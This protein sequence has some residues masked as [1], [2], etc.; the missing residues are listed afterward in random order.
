MTNNGNGTVAGGSRS[1]ELAGRRLTIEPPSGRKASRA[2]ALLRAINDQA[3]ELVEE[4]GHFETSYSATHYIELDR[5]NAELRYGPE[6]YVR[7]GELVVYPDGHPKAG[8]PVMVPGPLESMTEEAWQS[9]GNKLR[10]PQAPSF[11]VKL[12]N[13][14]RHPALEAAEENVYRLVSLFAMSNADVKAYRRDGTLKE[15]LEKLADELLDDAG[16]DELLE[17]AVIAGEVID[18][19]FRSKVE[20]IG[21][22]RLGNALRALGVEPR[23]LQPQTAPQPAQTAPQPTP[24][25]PDGAAT[26]TTTPTSSSSTSHGDG[27][28]VSDGTPTP[29]STHPGERSPASAVGSSSSG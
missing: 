21:Q 17:L 14:I 22:G 6:P 18:E 1:L 20:K 8:E 3:P 29:S 4:W 15:E 16:L 28:T 27:P 24:A 10:L 5:A 19:Q 13:I 11:E 9:T 12:A 2:F 25:T 26:S 23:A 7:E